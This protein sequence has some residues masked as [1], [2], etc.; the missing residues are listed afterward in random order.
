MTKGKE[1][2]AL[3]IMCSELKKEV[4]QLKAELTELRENKGNNIPK[5]VDDHLGALTSGLNAANEYT[6]H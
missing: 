1:M 5:E 2:K 4:E 3:F 6:E